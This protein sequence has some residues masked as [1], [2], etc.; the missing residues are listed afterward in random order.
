MS[1]S[2]KV[3]KVPKPILEMIKCYRERYHLDLRDFW[4]WKQKYPKKNDKANKIRELL[5]FYEFDTK[6]LCEEFKEEK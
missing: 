3:S 2:L 1:G 5:E 6:K 4:K